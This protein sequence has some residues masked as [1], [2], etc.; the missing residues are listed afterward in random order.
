MD[1]R[2]GLVALVGVD[3]E[4]DCCHV[5]GREEGREALQRRSVELQAEVA[6]KR[7]AFV[8]QPRL[9]TDDG[10]VPGRRTRA[11]GERLARVLERDLARSSGG[12]ERDGGVPGAAREGPARAPAAQR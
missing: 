4:R 8:L 3:V 5:E 11:A 12:C 7:C 2:V 9:V 1:A 10:E 6:E